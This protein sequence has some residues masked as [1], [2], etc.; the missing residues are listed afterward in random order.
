[1]MR[2]RSWVHPRQKRDVVDPPRPPPRRQRRPRLRRYKITWEIVII[3]YIFISRYLHEKKDVLYYNCT[4][5]CLLFKCL[6]YKYLFYWPTAF[7]MLRPT[8]VP[9]LKGGGGKGRIVG[10]SQVL[11]KTSAKP[12]GFGD[13]VPSDQSIECGFWSRWDLLAAPFSRGVARETYLLRL[14]CH[15]RMM[16]QSLN[17]K[18]FIHSFNTY[19]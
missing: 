18:S 16:K 3:I 11:S 14:W 10:N 1:M 8:A 6:L 15:P 4:I 12:S 5:K 19:L 2:L 17:S 7:A 9:M 13:T